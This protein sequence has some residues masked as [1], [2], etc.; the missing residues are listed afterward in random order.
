MPG[1]VPEVPKPSTEVL[2]GGP[3]PVSLIKSSWPLGALVGAAAV[4]LLVVFATRGHHDSAPISEPTPTPVAGS[5]QAG[6]TPPAA[7]QPTNAPPL[8]PSEQAATVQTAGAT[9]AK[10]LPAKT[11]KAS[12]SRTATAGHSQKKPQRSK[13]A[14]SRATKA[15]DKKKLHH[16]GPPPAHGPHPVQGRPETATP[17]KKDSGFALVPE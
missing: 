5:T 2:S 6:A 17:T 7:G 11:S 14:A 10:A 3:A 8:Q 12:P 13:T 4:L 1:P 16:A 15:S 9:A